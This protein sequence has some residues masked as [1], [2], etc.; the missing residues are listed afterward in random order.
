[1]NENMSAKSPLCLLSI[2]PTGK[3]VFSLCLPTMLWSALVVLVHGCLSDE[4]VAFNCENPVNARFL[5]HEVCNRH[6][7]K[8][9]T[10]QFS[11]VQRSS[12]S[13][14]VGF[15]C[16]GWKTSEVGYC[17]R[18]SHNKFSAE[19]KFNVPIQFDHD[20]CLNMVNKRVI[21]ANSQSFP[22]KMNS[23]NSFSS[24]SH[25]SVKYNGDNVECT[26]DS[27]RLS[28]GSVN[29]N[30][31]RMEHY[32]I[33]ISQNDLMHVKD[34]VVNPYSQTKLGDFSSGHSYSKSKTFVWKTTPK[35][36]SLVKIA[37]INLS[38]VRSDIWFSNS[39]QIQF[40]ILDNFYDQGCQIKLS[41]TNGYDVFLV[42]ATESTTHLKQISA[43]DIDISTDSQLRFDFINSKLAGVLRSN[44]KNSQPTCT[45]IQETGLSVTARVGDNVFIRNLGDVSVRFECLRVQVAPVQDD[46]CFSM[47]KVQDI[48]AN[49]WF[50]EPNT[51]ILLKKAANVPCS[52]ANVPVYQTTDNQLISFSPDRKS[53]KASHA[54]L[55]NAT[56]INTDAAGL[57][58]KVLVSEWLSYAFLQQMAKHSFSLFTQA[59]CHDSSCH[60]GQDHPAEFFGRLGR[61]ANR[62]ASL[63]EKGI[64][65]GIDLQELGGYC[66]I[67]ICFAGSLYSIFAIFSWFIRLTLLKDPEVGCFALL[68]RSTFPGI[69]L[70]AKNVGSNP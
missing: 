27:L 11:I 62:I 40:H 3:A 46:S 19:S 53:V 23:I 15:V 69:F 39:H 42:E 47:L 54:P 38:S 1:M 59:L 5:D 8:L 37:D 9:L 49:I 17:G 7:D 32:L 14:I 67:F 34:S 35:K 18:Y 21:V 33:E 70:V 13:K 29:S 57:Y 22:L 4:L 52:P 31:I 61:S 48:N 24:L 16:S 55:D 36:C 44:F 20:D 45:K 65:F 41:K 51:R 6:S 43:L 50:L 58:P 30:M 26:G 25:G 66:S 64:W 2:K 63:A 68:C 60:Q 10:K 28:D 56:E 12:V